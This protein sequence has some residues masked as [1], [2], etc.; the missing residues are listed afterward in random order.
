[1]ETFGDR[2]HSGSVP[3]CSDLNGRRRGAVAVFRGCRGSHFFGHFSHH[4]LNRKLGLDRRFLG[5]FLQ[6][7]E[8]IG[9]VLLPCPAT[10]GVM[11]KARTGGDQAA[12]DDVLLEAA[13]I[14]LEATNG[15]F[16][17]NTRG[18]LEGGRRDK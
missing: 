8:L 1:M 15:R 18:L 13:Q 3:I 17:E 9:E 16:R 6:L 11:R 5:L 12:N 7:L 2:P 14:V 10:L 4:V